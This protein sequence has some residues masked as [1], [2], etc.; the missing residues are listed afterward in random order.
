M[1]VATGIRFQ[2]GELKFTWDM[3]KHKL[4]AQKHG[5]AFEEAAS[6]WLDPGAVEKYDEE[7]SQQEDRW[8]RIGQSVRGA[9]LVTWSAARIGEGGDFIRIIGA[10]R[11]TPH[12]RRLYEQEESSS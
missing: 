1:Y 10:R 8:L 6:T 3:R 7:H 11:A 5:V 12:E 2:I 9:L 4:N